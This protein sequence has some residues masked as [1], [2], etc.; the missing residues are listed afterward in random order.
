MAL[1]DFPALDIQYEFTEEVGFD[2]V[3]VTAYPNG[4]E[5]R[6]QTAAASRRKFHLR[7]K[8]LS[9]TDM[10]SLYNFY[11]ARHGGLEPFNF[12]N[13]RTSEVI[14]VRFL[15]QALSRTMFAYLLESGGL[16]LFEVINES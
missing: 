13:P 14:T 1:L 16:S 5:Q 3:L 12:T 10:D 8:V 7:F 4:L 11:M 6:I 2:D 9:Q 15:N